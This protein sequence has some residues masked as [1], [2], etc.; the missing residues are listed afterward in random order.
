ME[1]DHTLTVALAAAPADVYDAIASPAGLRGWWTAGADGSDEVNGVFRLTFRPDHWTE[2]RI[3]RLDPGRT[4][5]WTCVAQ[6]EP[7]FTP[8]DEWVGTTISFTL[9]P[10]PTGTVLRFAHHG[11]RRLECH[12]L[13]QRGWD[14]YVGHSLK[15][16]L[17][18]GTGTPDTRSEHRATVTLTTRRQPRPR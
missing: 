10:T 6:H 8:T 9:E 11:L 3:D 18:T 17:E 5:G 14:F 7:G 12:Q 15:A 13:C 4:V 1:T 2:M 16:L